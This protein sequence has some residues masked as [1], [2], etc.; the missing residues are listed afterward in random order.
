[1]GTPA[2]T[3]ELMEIVPSIIEDADVIADGSPDKT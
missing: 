2:P 3:S 1:M